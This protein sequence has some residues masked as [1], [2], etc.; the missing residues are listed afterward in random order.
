M[1]TALVLL[2]C[3]LLFACEDTGARNDNHGYGWRYDWQG[4]SGL[5]VRF[6]DSADLTS[7]STIKVGLDD[8][9]P[10]GAIEQTYLDTLSCSG[11]SAPVAPLVIITGAALDPSEHD[12][13]GRYYPDT[14]LIVVRSVQEYPRGWPLEVFKH[15]VVHFVLHQRDASTDQN[16]NHGSAL[17]SLCSS[18]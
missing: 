17:F 6:E 12:G 4:A 7:L 3:L 13:Q 11:H 14:G 8:T 9:R 16:V 18:V 15:Q 5:R 2:T 1:R 10:F